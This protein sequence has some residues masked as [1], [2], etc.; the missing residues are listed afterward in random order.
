MKT[1]DL[2]MIVGDDLILGI[3]TSTNKVVF[4]ASLETIR[5]GISEQLTDALIKALGDFML[6]QDDTQN[7]HQCPFATRG[8]AS[9]A[10]AVR[11]CAPC[12]PSESIEIENEEL[13]HLHQTIQV[14]KHLVRVQDRSTPIRLRKY[15]PK[16]LDSLLYQTENL[17]NALDRFVL[18]RL[19]KRGNSR[20]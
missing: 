4:R 9:L 11:Q 3:D 2:Q 10:S 14:V 20:H 17:L 7:R 12:A 13:A 8:S 6:R 1:E 18:P 16:L 5:A 15:D 19:T